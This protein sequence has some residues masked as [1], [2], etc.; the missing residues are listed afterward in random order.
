M[1][2]VMQR[3]RSMRLRSKLMPLLLAV[4]ALFGMAAAVHAHQFSVGQLVIADPWS[5]PTG[6]GMP[7][8]VA[9]LS[10]R[11]EGSQEDTLLSASTPVAARVE[12][13]RTIISQ[14]MARMR[15]A[16]DLRIAPGATL[17]AEPGGLH[18]MLVELRAP[19]SAGTTVPLSLRF[20][21]AGEI[22]VSVSVQAE[23]HAHE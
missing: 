19:L 8:G 14:G 6:P 11:N 4:S 22:T 2:A 15:P 5:R 20:E 18:L 13:H 12:F 21:R 10:I 17:T 7:M 1:R 9:Y 16:D 23:G 3:L